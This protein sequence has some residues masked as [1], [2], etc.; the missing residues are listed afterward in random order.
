MNKDPRTATAIEPN[1]LFTGALRGGTLNWDLYQIG[2]NLHADMYAQYFAN[3]AP[4][5]QTD[6]YESNPAWIATY[7]NSY[8]STLPIS[9]TQEAIRIAGQD[10]LAVNKVAQ[11]R[12]WR[13]WLFT[14]SPITGEM[15]LTPKRR[16]AERQHHPQV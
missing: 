11:A 6:R 2:Q 5:F 9:N 13:V 3:N 10:P 15:Y 16:G 7:W 14:A 8:Y 12:I 1:L 4:G